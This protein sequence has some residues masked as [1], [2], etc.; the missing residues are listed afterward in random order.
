MLPGEI[1]AELNERRTKTPPAP[2]QMTCTVSCISPKGNSTVVPGSRRGV[3]TAGAAASVVVR[4]LEASPG[5]RRV[6]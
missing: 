3:V 2:T 1:R 6:L 5:F 4:Q